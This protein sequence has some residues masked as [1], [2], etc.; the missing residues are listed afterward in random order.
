MHLEKYSLSAFGADVGSVKMVYAHLEY[1]SHN[2][3]G[4]CHTFNGDPFI[5]FHSD[6]W[7][8]TIKEKEVHNSKPSGSENRFESYV[9]R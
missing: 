2:K 4:R 1:K 7:R 6:S 8:D 3:L 5:S 9:T